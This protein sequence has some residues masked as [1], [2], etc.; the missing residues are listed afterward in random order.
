M[1]REAHEFQVCQRKKEDWRERIILEQK[2]SGRGQ[3]DKK[4]QCDT[5][6]ETERER[7]KEREKERKREREKNKKRERERERFS[8]ADTA[9]LFTPFSDVELLRCTIQ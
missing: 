3:R 1:Q 5:E 9:S 7:Q 4:R 6:R 8:E 2:E